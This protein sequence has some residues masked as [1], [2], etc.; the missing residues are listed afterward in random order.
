[1]GPPRP[2]RSRLPS[3]SP[4]PCSCYPSPPIVPRLQG[5]PQIPYQVP[6]RPLPSQRIRQVRQPVR[7]PVGAAARAAAVCDGLVRAGRGGWVA[8]YVGGGERAGR[9]QGEK[10]GGGG[11]GGVSGIGGGMEGDVLT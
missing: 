7:D 10:F 11:G 5:S 8:D 3:H 1:M 6:K 9:E 4:S 2:R